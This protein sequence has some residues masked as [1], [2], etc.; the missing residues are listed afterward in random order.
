MCSLRFVY[1]NPVDDRIRPGKIHVLENAGC[2]HG[3]GRA[4]AAVKRAALLYEDRLPWHHVAH[5]FEAK[6]G[7]RYALGRDEEFR[8]LLRVVATDDQRPYS[9]RIAEGKQP[10]A[11][12]QG[13]DGIGP[14]AATV[15]VCHRG[16]YGFRVE[17]LAF[18][19]ELELVRE[20][21]QQDF[22]IGTGV[23]VPEVLTKHLLLERFGIGEVAVVPEDDSKGRIHVKRLRLPGVERGSRGGVTTVCNA[24][25]SRQRPACCACGTRRAPGPGPLCM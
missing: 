15:N 9:I 25:A 13:H 12:N 2:K 17:F 1:R 4:L 22:R 19:R 14:A 8:A 7:Q 5:Q 11:G 21:I 20:D 10:I 24:C 6:G 23:D 18:C 3:F 16:E